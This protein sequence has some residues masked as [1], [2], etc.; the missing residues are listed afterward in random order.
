[1]RSEVLTAVLPK[2]QV[3]WEVTLCRW[4]KDFKRT[5]KQTKNLG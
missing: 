3:F 5:V 1:V 2:I 4:T